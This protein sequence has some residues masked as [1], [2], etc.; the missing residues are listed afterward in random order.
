MATAAHTPLK[1]PAAGIVLGTSGSWEAITSGAG[2]GRTFNRSLC[3]FFTVKNTTG[4]AIDVTIL[5]GALGE[6]DKAGTTIASKTE[7]VPAND[8]ITFETHAF[9]ASPAGVVTVEAASAGLE[10]LAFYGNA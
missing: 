7:S 8:Y 9:L 5:G 6:A 4:S 1:V 10:V 2:N 3:Q